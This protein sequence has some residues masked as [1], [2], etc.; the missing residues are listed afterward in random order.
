MDNCRRCWVHIES[1]LWCKKC[2]EKVDQELKGEISRPFEYY[3]RHY[4][5]RGKKIILYPNINKNG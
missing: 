4:I 2:R 5:K 1:G 3:F